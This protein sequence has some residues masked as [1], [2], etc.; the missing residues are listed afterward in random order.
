MNL[1]L[2]QILDLVGTL[3]DTP[4]DNTARERFRRYLR[5]SIST[6]GA[7]HDYIEECLRTSGTQYNRALQ[8]L[9]NH[10]GALI[11]FD[12]EFGRYQG[13]QGQTGHDGLWRLDDFAI[14]VEVKTTDAYSIKTATLTGSVDQLISEQRVRDWDHAL[15]LYIV[16]RP[17]VGLEQLENAILAERRTHQLRVARVEDIRSLAE[18]VQGRHI[19]QAEA[20]TLLRPSGVRVGSTVGLLARVANTAVQAE[21]AAIE[22]AVV[23]PL[24]APDA[25]RS[26]ASALPREA[27]GT[28]SG[29]T[30]SAANERMHLLTPVSAE[31]P[32]S[33]EAIIR[34]LLDL[35]WYVFGDNT[36][37]RKRLKPGDRLCFYESRKGVVAK[38]EVSSVPDRMLPRDLRGIARRPEKFPW[39]FRVKNV[40]Y[41]FDNPVVIDAELRARLEA[42]TA[43]DRDPN[44]PWSWLVQG[45]CRVTEHD[46]RVLTNYDHSR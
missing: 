41:F 25:V 12:V 14:V 39:S 26:S 34:S 30:R 23:P 29:A 43:N 32:D 16:G 42:F 19:T 9:I 40:Q 27:P 6:V 5:D 45:T 28:E 4:G 35:G 38:A 31:G 46:F 44:G 20:V 7:V 22:N 10:T 36:T 15:G 24:E 3:D 33:G 17:D 13:V 18:L 2:A 21:V 11:G 37:G 1:T 8:D